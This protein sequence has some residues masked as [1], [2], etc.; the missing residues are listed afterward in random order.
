MHKNHPVVA[1]KRKAW[2]VES[3]DK[4]G[5]KMKKQWGLTNYLPDRNLEDDD[6]SITRFKEYLSIESKKNPL[7]IDRERVT[8]RMK[9]TFADR[10]KLIVKELATA[11]IVREQYPV[12]F[13]EAEV[14]ISPVL[15]FVIRQ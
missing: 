8:D 2:I 12:L 3:A 15:K 10:R 4:G 5:T 11:E 13:S 1:L 6:A 9:R 7:K 14:S